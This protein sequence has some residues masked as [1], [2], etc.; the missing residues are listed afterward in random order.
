MDFPNEH[1]QRSASA[2]LM[3]STPQPERPVDEEPRVEDDRKVR[4]F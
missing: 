4:H 3:R 1:L 2:R